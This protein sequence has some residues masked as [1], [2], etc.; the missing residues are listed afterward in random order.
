MAWAEP[1]NT[2]S[3]VPITGATTAPHPTVHRRNTAPSIHPQ[4]HRP[5][6]LPQHPAVERQ[7]L[8]GDRIPVVALHVDTPPC[9]HGLPLLVTQRCGRAQRRNQRRDTGVDPPNRSRGP[10]DP[11]RAR[12]GW[13]RPAD[14]RTALQ[15]PPGRSSRTRQPAARPW[16]PPTTH[17]RPSKHR[18][19]PPRR[20]VG[21]GRADARRPDNP[22]R[23]ICAAASR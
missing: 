17:Q 20:R 8:L 21:V 3:A 1:P 19:P 11:P 18:A 7:R 5:L 4:A 22:A 23:T 12:R 10:R 15:P 13:R 2:R 16:S 14:L 6:A 9:A